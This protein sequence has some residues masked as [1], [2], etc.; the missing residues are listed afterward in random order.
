MALRAGVEKRCGRLGDGSGDVAGSAARLG[1]GSTDSAGL[2]QVA[3]LEAV[4]TLSGRRSSPR[5]KMPRR[6]RSDSGAIAS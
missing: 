1:G 2:S 3:T 5:K 6:Q 4:C